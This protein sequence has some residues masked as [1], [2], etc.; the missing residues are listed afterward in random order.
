MDEKEYPYHQEMAGPNHPD[1]TGQQG[2]ATS[3][4]RPTRTVH[5]RAVPRPVQG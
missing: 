5:A 2:R 4:L 3:P 1:P